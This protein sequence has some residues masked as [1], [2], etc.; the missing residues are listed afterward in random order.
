MSVYTYII[1][2]AYYIVVQL[3]NAW[4]Y[5]RDIMRLFIKGGETMPRAKREDGKNPRTVASNKYQAANYDRINI[6]VSKGYKEKVKNAADA[7]GV[8]LSAYIV[9]AIDEKISKETSI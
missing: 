1:N 8:S 3:S 2:C 7:A 9:G 4:Y 6:L 5:K